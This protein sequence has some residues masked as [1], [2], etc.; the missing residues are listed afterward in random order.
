MVRDH[1]GRCPQVPARMAQEF[2][3]LKGQ[4]AQGATDSKQYWV[5]AAQ[6][7]GMI[8]ADSGIERPEASQVTAQ[9]M[10]PYGATSG[11][12]IQEEQPALVNVSE[13]SNR[14]TPFLYELMKHLQLVHLLASERVGKRKGLPIGLEGLGCKYCCR[15]GRLGFSRCFPLRRRALP[16]HMHDLYRH[17]LRCPLCPEEVKQ[18]LQ[19]VH[20]SS[21][22]RSNASSNNPSRDLDSY[23]VIWAK[24]GRQRD[25]TTS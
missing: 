19:Q 7:L 22:N 4:N 18:Q 25:L 17:C 24:L 14:F 13:D 2:Q 8:N 21:N 16:S 20:D 9:Q 10:P 5:Y 1:F 23:A 3:T 6:K 11:E 12:A 15:K